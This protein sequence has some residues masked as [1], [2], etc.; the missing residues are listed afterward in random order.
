M[1]TLPLFVPSPSDK[2]LDYFLQQYLKFHFLICLK[3]RQAAEKQ[4]K[5]LLVNVQAGTGSAGSYDS[6]RLNSE[7]WT[8]ATVQSMIAKK[9]IFWQVTVVLAVNMFNHPRISRFCSRDLKNKNNVNPI[10][11]ASVVRVVSRCFVAG[12]S[13]SL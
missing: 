8:H 1:S 7:L 3:L 13:R 12:S 5:W 11:E 6:D 4:E 9:C 2:Y 10:L